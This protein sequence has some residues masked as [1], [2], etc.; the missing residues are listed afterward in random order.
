MLIFQH[1]I[2]VISIYDSTTAEEIEGGEGVLQ[3]PYRYDTKQNMQG[4]RPKWGTGREKEIRRIEVASNNSI[5]L[6]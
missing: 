5:Q 3:P 1:G 2:L 4:L 6:K